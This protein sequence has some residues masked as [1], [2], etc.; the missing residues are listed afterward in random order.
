MLHCTPRRL[1]SSINLQNRYSSAQP[2]WLSSE[3]EEGNPSR[4]ERRVSMLWYLCCDW[5]EGCPLVHIS[6][7]WTP[8][9]WTLVWDPPDLFQTGHWI[10]IRWEKP[11]IVSDP[12]WIHTRNIELCP[13]AT[14][15]C[16]PGPQISLGQIHFWCN[17]IDFTAD[18]PGI[19]LPWQAKFCTSLSQCKTKLTIDFKGVKWV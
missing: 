12:S 11:L 8:A 10:P 9:A 19:T 13:I 7:M 3:L 18:T 1:K 15:L 5:Q 17:S 2:A 14:P 6:E 4:N 16:H